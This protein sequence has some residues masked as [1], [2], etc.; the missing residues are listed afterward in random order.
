MSLPLSGKGIVITRPALQAQKLA[1]RISE[2]GGDPIVFPA[3]EI[4]PVT[5]DSL[6]ACIAQLGKFD[7]AVFISP[8]A[9]R[10]GMAAIRAGQQIWPPTMQVFAIGPATARE[11][12]Q[13]A[14]SDVI[15]AADGDSEALLA[16]PQ[17][18]HVAD[19]HWVIFRGK[20]GRELLAD[21]LSVRGAV[22]T[23]AECYRRVC[24][25][26][27]AEPLLLRWRVGGIHAVTIH[28]TETLRNFMHMLGEAGLPYLRTT[29]VFA[30]HEKIAESA[31]ACGIQ[32]VNV[33]TGGNSGLMASLIKW[34]RVRNE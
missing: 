14:V 15:H 29:P 25:T 8:N 16:L 34:F 4:E 5:D 22:V 27:D 10:H 9:V 18:Q 31:R 7:A 28:S 26:T 11:L 19:Q 33:A 21:T 13:H 1:H 3:L 24:P 23:Y 6:T 17:L 12:A 30:P 32:H 20:G 2:A